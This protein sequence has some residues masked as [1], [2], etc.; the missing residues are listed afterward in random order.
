MRYTVWVEDTCWVCRN[1]G[2]GPKVHARSDGKYNPI[3]PCSTVPRVVQAGN[4]REAIKK[5][6]AIFQ[7]FL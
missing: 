2:T 1:S 3:S 6:R 5:A 4:R 7:R